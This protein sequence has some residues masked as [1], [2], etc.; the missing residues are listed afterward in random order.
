MVGELCL[1]VPSAFCNIPVQPT[2]V[3][4]GGGAPYL[5]AWEFSHNPAR[6]PPALPPTACVTDYTYP[7]DYTTAK[8]RA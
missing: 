2:S 4:V 5:P 1:A 6:Y 3:P 7:I 8:H